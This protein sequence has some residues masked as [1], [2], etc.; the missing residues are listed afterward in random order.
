MIVQPGLL[1]IK[2]SIKTTTYTSLTHYVFWK[3]YKP[4][5]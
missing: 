3:Q 4:G 2:F 1:R 5:T